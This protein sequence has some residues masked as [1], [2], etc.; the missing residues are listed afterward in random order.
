VKNRKAETRTENA[1]KLKNKIKINNSKY[2]LQP[3]QN[4]KRRCSWIIA[5]T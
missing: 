5:F 2:K 4:W 1:N 3:L